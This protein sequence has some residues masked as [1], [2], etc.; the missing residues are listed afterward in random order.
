MKEMPEKKLVELCQGR[1][2]VLDCPVRML[3]I[4]TIG[5]RIKEAKKTWK[6]AI[7]KVCVCF[8]GVSVLA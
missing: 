6:I 5:V 7:K 4:K 3:K 1:Y 2:E 8:D